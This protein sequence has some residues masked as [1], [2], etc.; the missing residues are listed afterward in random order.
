[1]RYIILLSKDSIK[2]IGSNK[3]SIEKEEQILDMIKNIKIKILAHDANIESF[4]FVLPKFSKISEEIVHLFIDNL[5]IKIR[6]SRA[7]DFLNNGSSETIS[8]H[9]KEY[10]K[11][12]Q[13]LVVISSKHI[14]QEIPSK[15]IKLYPSTEKRFEKYA[16]NRSNFNEKASVFIAISDDDEKIHGIN[17]A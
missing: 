16:T 15:L 8:R 11:E 9:L 1:M 3:L 5:G 10:S 4:N 14:L 17:Q 13:M 6:V 7:E 2:G 12:T